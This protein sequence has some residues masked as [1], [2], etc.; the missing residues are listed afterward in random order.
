MGGK[1]LVGSVKA[2]GGS[3]MVCKRVRGL[4]KGFKRKSKVLKEG[5][6]RIGVQGLRI[7]NSI[8]VYIH[9]YKLLIN[10]IKT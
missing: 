6:V 7:G 2:V 5:I 1:G 9:I 4:Y 10:H 3:V 8:R